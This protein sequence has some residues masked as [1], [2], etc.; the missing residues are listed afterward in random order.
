[1]I[2]S[3]SKED[4]QTEVQRL[5]ST[6]K[7]KKAEEPR[8]HVIGMAAWRPTMGILLQGRLFQPTARDEFS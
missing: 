1:M 3:Y 4:N 5:A 6:R 2:S 8:I 7:R